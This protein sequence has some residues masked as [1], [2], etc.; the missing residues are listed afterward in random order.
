M[1][2]IQNPVNRRAELIQECPDPVLEGRN[3]AGFS[4][5]PGRNCLNRGGGRG[6]PGRTGTPAGFGALED[7]VWTQANKGTVYVCLHSACSK[8]R[9]NSRSLRRS[10]VMKP[11]GV[12]LLKVMTRS[13]QTQ[14]NGRTDGRTDRRMDAYLVPL[15][16][17]RWLCKRE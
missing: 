16:P 7:R 8:H 9:F 10:A 4:V 11:K 17:L 2:P 3:P 15:L 6:L 1:K 5:Q 14:T 13:C 12:T